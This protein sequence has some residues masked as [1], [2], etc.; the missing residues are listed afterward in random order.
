MN[1][2]LIVNLDI[3]DDLFYCNPKHEI[4]YEMQ[5]KPYFAETKQYF[6]NKKKILVISGGGLK[7]ITFI[8]AMKALDDHDI[9]SKIETF[10]GTSVG[11]LLIILYLIGFDFDELFDFIKFFDASKMSSL[12]K[13][14]NFI[15]NYGIDDGKRISIILTK[16]FQSKNINPKIT[17]EELFKIT[18]KTVIITTVCLNTMALTFLSHTSHPK[19]EILLAIK[20]AI[21]IPI[22][23]SPVIY[24]GNMYVDGACMDNFPISIFHE[25]IND[26][27]GLNIEVNTCVLN[28]INSIDEYLFQLLQCIKKSKDHTYYNDNVITIKINWNNLIDIS[29]IELNK[30]IELFSNGYLTTLD[31]INAHISN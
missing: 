4:N 24:N 14:S 28:E 31:F 12:D 23:F 26:V 9:L 21:A 7:G 2:N 22:I 8:G 25:Q 27:I 17:F 29:D 20:M 19:M 15:T 16:L 1:N 11:A 18:N 30:K 13:L 10:A 3:L 6:K 5:I